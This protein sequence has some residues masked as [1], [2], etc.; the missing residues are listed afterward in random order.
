MVVDERDPAALTD[1]A[2]GEMEP[3][4]LSELDGWRGTCLHDRP[5]M[6]YLQPDERPEYLLRSIGT[7]IEIRRRDGT[8]ERPDDVDDGGSTRR[9]FLLITDRGIHYVAGHE[10]G[11]SVREFDYDD[12]VGVDWEES[13]TTATLSITDGTGTTYRFRTNPDASAVPAAADYVRERAP[14]VDPAGSRAPDRTW[15]PLVAAGLSALFPPLGYV[16]T[17]ELW[18]AVAALIRIVIA[19]V[20]LAVVYVI[21]VLISGVILPGIGPLLYTLALVA[22]LVYVHVGY[23]RETYADT[24]ALNEGRREHGVVDDALGGLEEADG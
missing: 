22:T 20:V 15:S 13:L 8:E 3:A 18:V 11:D 7:G 10:D 23:A 16:Y 9:Q 5:L 19:Y 2:A 1:A 24:V 21:G 4:H 6:A 14:A 17:R 12:V